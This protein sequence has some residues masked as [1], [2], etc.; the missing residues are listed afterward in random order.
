MSG[1]Q[2]DKGALLPSH[3]PESAFDDLKPAYT[4]GQ[5][6]AEADRCLYCFDA[7]C[8]SVCPTA[9]DIPEFI[10]K[11]ASGNY[12][13]SARSILSANILGLSCSMVCPVEVLCV[14]DCVFNHLG[15]K[16]IAIGRLQRFATE[17]AYD[18]DIR[19][20]KAG[21][22]SGFRVALVGGGPASLAAA[23]ELTRLGHECV[24]L[25]GRDLPGGLNTTGVAPYKMRS[26][27]A[28]REVNYVKEIGF[29]VRTGAMVGRDVSFDEL[30]RDYDAIFL[31][32]G[33]G[34]DSQ[35][36]LAGTDLKG[37]WGACALIEKLKN[38]P[39]DGLGFDLAAVRSAVVVGG[40]NTAIDV[41]RELRGLGVADV[42][43]VYRRDAAAMPGYAHEAD[44]ARREGVRF[45]LQANPVAF[46]ASADEPGQVGAV[47]LIEMRAGEPDAS[48][49]RRPEPVAGSE[50]RID[51]DLVAV[52]TGQERLETLF[53]AVSG[54]EVSN[55]KLVVNPE[56][57]RTGNPRY[58]SGGDCA[59]GAKEV[60][61]AAAEG[62]LAATS[63]DK[64]LRDGSA[65][66]GD[67]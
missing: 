11:I 41:V 29:E 26:E 60:V 51:A 63:I 22:A 25:E 13:G 62:K 9:I 21:E 17:W 46:L 20:W 52:A 42:V 6:R 24:V 45:R 38:S 4:E 50:F 57:G 2:A 43:M 5:A 19:F 36:G 53:S 10:R 47:E 27:A 55:S 40:G 15:D 54:L 67:S 30:E 35:L 31:G 8:I 33:L 44:Y 61:N 48:G 66:R 7:P 1:S 16:P 3:R 12:R 37:V 18:R 34:A 23:H 58:W 32:V 56:T 14:G 28:L 65:R 49:R 64:A 39:S 59:N